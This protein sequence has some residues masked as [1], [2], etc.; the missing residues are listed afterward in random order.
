MRKKILFRVDEDDWL[1]IA[2][3]VAGIGVTILYR[4]TI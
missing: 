4:R 2:C 1:S 3:P